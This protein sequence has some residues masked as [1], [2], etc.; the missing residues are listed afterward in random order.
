[1][2][3]ISSA[4]VIEQLV[5]RADLGVYLVHVLLNDSRKSI[6]VRIAGLSCLEEDIGVLSG[7][8]VAWMVW[9]QSVLAECCNG[10][11]ISHILQILV[12]PGLDLLDLMRCTETV[13]EVDE[14]NFAL[15]CCQMSNGS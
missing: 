15:D 3:C 11:Q 4:V 2:L 8:S 1:M 12:I 7:T 14:R 6:I 5:V 9:I 13:E 10:I